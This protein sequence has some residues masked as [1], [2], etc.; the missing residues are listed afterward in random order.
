[1][2]ENTNGDKP[3]EEG[4]A[5]EEEEISRRK[6]SYYPGDQ[7]GERLSAATKGSFKEAGVENSGVRRSRVQKP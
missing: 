4:R 2:R 5:E 3:S 6:R 7:H 1:M